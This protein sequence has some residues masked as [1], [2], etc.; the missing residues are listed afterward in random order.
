MSDQPSD[1]VIET[2]RGCV[3]QMLKSPICFDSFQ[4]IPNG[5]RHRFQ[6]GDSG[7]LCQTVSVMKSHSGMPGVLCHSVFTTSQCFLKHVCIK[8][9]SEL[10]PNIFQDAFSVFTQIFMVLQKDK[11]QTLELAPLRIIKFCCYPPPDSV[12]FFI[13]RFNHME[14]VKNDFD[15][16]EMGLKPT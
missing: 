4:I 13:H 9:F 1:F 12:E 5:S 8:E 10:I 3:G 16:R 7:F 11:A 2:F 15:L 14:M 6:F